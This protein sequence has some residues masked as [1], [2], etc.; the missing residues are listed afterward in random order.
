MLWSPAAAIGDGTPAVVFTSD[1]D[2][3]D[4]LLQNDRQIS[5]R[6]I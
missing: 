2:D 4:R 1:P 6:A 3:L 5:V